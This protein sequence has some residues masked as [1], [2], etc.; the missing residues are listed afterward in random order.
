MPMVHTAREIIVRLNQALNRGRLQ[1]AEI[2]V[3]KGTSI[4]VVLYIKPASPGPL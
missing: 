1:L 4:D 2:V 3:M